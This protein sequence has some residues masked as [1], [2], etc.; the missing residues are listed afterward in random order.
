MA[1]IVACQVLDVP[2]HAALDLEGVGLL[3]TFQ[4]PLKLL[5]IHGWIVRSSLAL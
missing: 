3:A 2:G 4:Q 1:R 5:L